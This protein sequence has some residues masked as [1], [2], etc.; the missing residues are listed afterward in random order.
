M[1]LSQELSVLT[2]ARSDIETV[3]MFSLNKHFKVIELFIIIN[4]ILVLS[5]N[6][7]RKFN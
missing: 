3:Y 2:G 7:Y 4:C 5:F 1:S 6:H